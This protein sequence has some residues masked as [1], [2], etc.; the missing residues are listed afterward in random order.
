MRAVLERFPSLLLSQDHNKFVDKLSYVFLCYLGFPFLP[1]GCH[2][3]VTTFISS[4]I[5]IPKH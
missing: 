5:P 4:V 3:L 2:I 1:L